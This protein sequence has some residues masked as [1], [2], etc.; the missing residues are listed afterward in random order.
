MK[1]Q[2]ILP[3]LFMVLF[4]VTGWL[5]PL[6]GFTEES[7]GTRYLK[8]ISKAFAEVARKVSPTVVLIQSEKV[9][10]YKRRTTPF[11][12][13]DPWFDNPLFREF[14]E[15]NAPFFRRFRNPREDEDDADM[16]EFH[17]QGQGSGFIIS[18]DGYI[19]TNCHVVDNA[20]KLHVQLADGRRFKAKIIGKDKRSDI[21]VIKIDAKNLP[22]L[23]LGDSDK[24]EVGEW[25]IA[26]G[27]PF[28]LSHTLTAGIVSAKGRSRVGITDYEDF[29]QTDAAINP[30]NSGGPLVNLEGKAVGINSAIFT[31]SGGYMGIGFAIPINMAKVIKNQLIRYGKV[32]RGYLGVYIQ[33]LDP[34]LK[35]SFKVDHGTVITKVFKDTPASRAGLKAGDVIIAFDGEKIKDSGHLRNLVALSRPG[36]TH[37]FKILRNGKE[38][39]LKIKIGELPEDGKTA[40][41]RERMDRDDGEATSEKFGFTVSPLTREIVKR[42]QLDVHEG[43]VISEVR[44]GSMAW[45]AG[46][47]PG[48]VITQV[49]LHPVKNVDDFV[50][51]SKEDP[52]KILLLVYDRNGSRYVVLKR[53]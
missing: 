3:H 50:E 5:V 22:V 30:G 4:F 52:N 20:D 29:I 33:D 11:G 18:S 14:F 44:P 48:M 51:Y 39:T 6:T 7:S 27:N 8:Q 41:R 28:G 37:E 53:E 23:P 1:R 2:N 12:L 9:V 25:V 19:L 42:Y 21:A 17:Q 10:K 47:R 24:L 34:D 49:N 46:L 36:T 16:E 32:H 43:V 13:D 40:G 35:E 26:I 38:Q 45:Q 15:R 31:R